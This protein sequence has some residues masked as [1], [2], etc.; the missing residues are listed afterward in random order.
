MALSSASHAGIELDRVDLS[1]LSRDSFLPSKASAGPGRID[2]KSFVRDIF[3]NINKNESFLS[4]SAQIRDINQILKVKYSSASDIADVILKDAALTT[5]LLKLVN[6]SFYGQFSNK[7][8]ATISEAMI[9]LGTEEIKLAAASLKIYELMQDIANIRILKEK[10]LR[11]F[12]RSIIAHQIAVYENIKDAE[13]IQIIAMLYD[14]GEYLVARFAPG[15]FINIEILLDDTSLTKEQASKNIIGISYSELGRFI[16]SRW[17]LPQSIISA[18]KPVSNF[19]ILKSRL[20]ADELKQY[21]CSFSDELCQI[22]LDISGRHI[23]KKIIQLSDKYKSCLEM[24]HAKSIELLKTSHDK[25]KKHASILKMA[26]TR[27]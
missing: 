27:K 2:Y 1:R 5:K 13:M 15:V 7:G 17:N 20:S 11:A 14:F 10:A 9:I 26:R 4:F 6:S 23:G 3:I 19:D 22:E 12:Q 21:I 25:I 8:I 16:A 18:M 24:P